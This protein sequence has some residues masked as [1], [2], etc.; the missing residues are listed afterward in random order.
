M[1]KRWI[2]ILIILIAGLGC[3]YLIAD[4]SNSVGNAI[5]VVKDVS[6]GVPLS[7]K[8]DDTTSDVAKLVN[9]ST[10]ERIE[11]RCVDK[12]PQK[13]FTKSINSFQDKYNVELKNLSDKTIEHIELKD[14]DSGNITSFVLFEKE[15]HSFIMKLSGYKDSAQLEKDMTYIIENMQHDFKQNK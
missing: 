12:N 5:T 15:N 2:G 11:I 10:K 3:M 1:D 8:I 4:N 7:Y 14:V 9:P 13:A 6:I